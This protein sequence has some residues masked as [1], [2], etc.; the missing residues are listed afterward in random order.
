MY[1]CVTIIYIHI[2]TCIYNRCFCYVRI[3]N[4][5]RGYIVQKCGYGDQIKEND[6]GGEYNTH[7]DEYFVS[8]S[9]RKKLLSSWGDDTE[10]EPTETGCGN[11][12]CD[13]L[14]RKVIQWLARAKA[15]ELLAIQRGKTFL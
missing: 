14:F 9:K 7:W 3:F 13:Q 10:M 5:Q 2:Y 4:T 12:A 6:I 1:S 8:N 15:A 11:L